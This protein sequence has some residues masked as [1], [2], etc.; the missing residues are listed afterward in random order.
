MRTYVTVWRQPKR[1]LGLKDRL[2]E[3]L[4]YGVKGAGVRRREIRT[5]DRGESRAGRNTPNAKFIDP[6]NVPRRRPLPAGAEWEDE[7]KFLLAY[8]SQPR[9]GPK[10]ILSKLA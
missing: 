10:S 6:D 4:E 7:A 1:S 8:V 3:L 9:L 2:R 5:D